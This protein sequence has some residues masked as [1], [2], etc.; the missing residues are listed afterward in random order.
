MA[1]QPFNGWSLAREPTV[2]EVPLHRGLIWAFAILLFGVG[3]LL[4]T[5]AMIHRG[6]TELNPVLGYVFMYLP[7]AVALS[8]AIAAQLGT[9][10]WLYR[11]IDHP[12]RI[13]IPLWLSVYGATVIL[14]N[15]SYI[16]SL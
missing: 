3:D 13:L 5:T 2:L 7:T 6:G 14:W 1:T 15:L 8:F 10:Y 4:T 9:A 11:T 12:A 16:A